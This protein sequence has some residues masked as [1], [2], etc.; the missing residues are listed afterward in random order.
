MTISKENFFRGV[1]CWAQAPKNLIVEFD[2][3]FDYNGHPQG[4]AIVDA[5][6]TYRKGLLQSWNGEM[7]NWKHQELQYNPSQEGDKDDDI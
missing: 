5:F 1:L 4:I 3:T 7:R 6:T 2:G